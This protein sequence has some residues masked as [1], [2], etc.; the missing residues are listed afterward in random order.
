[1]K[2]LPERLM[3]RNGTFYCRMWVPRDLAQLY[4]RQ[5]IVVSLRTKDLSTAKT[6][7][8]DRCIGALAGIPLISTDGMRLLD[9]DLQTALRRRN[10]DMAELCCIILAAAVTVIN[11]WALSTSASAA[12]WASDGASLTP[13]GWLCLVVGNTIFW[14]LFFRLAWRHF[15]WALL[16][17]AIS[18]SDLRLVV[19]HPDGHAGL[20]FMARYPSGYTFFSLA[21]GS[22]IA[23]GLARQLHG[24]ALSLTAFT[25]ICAIWLLVVAVFFML[26]LVGPVLQIVRLKSETIALTLGPMQDFERAAERKALGQNTFADEAG[27]ET[28]SADV[29]P[30]YQA[31]V[32][33]STLLLN[34]NNVVPI[35]T[36]ALLPI[37]AV[38]LTVF[39]YAELGPI[40]KRLLLLS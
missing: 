30:I 13:A 36:Q 11:I 17:N 7:S 23:A 38:G 33:C 8:I 24:G 9:A 34:K 18:K 25:A 22:V 16:S 29:R 35:L 19:S 10:S 28:I 21:I 14:F 32:K 2:T 40:L 26:P 1:M 37:A 20:S 4:G 27:A 6:R 12:H 31:A 3:V 39:P 15:V 5:L